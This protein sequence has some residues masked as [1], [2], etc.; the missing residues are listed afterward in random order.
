MAYPDDLPTCV[1]GSLGRAKVDT[2]A[3]TDKDA[4][5]DADEYNEIKS[6][7]EGLAA[8]LQL[9]NARDVPAVVASAIA[10]GMELN[11]LTPTGHGE[12]ILPTHGFVRVT[13]DYYTAL[14]PQTAASIRYIYSDTGFHLVPS[15]YGGAGIVTING[16]A[17]IAVIASGLSVLIGDGANAWVCGSAAN[18]TAISAEIAA[19]AGDVQDDLDAHTTNVSNAHSVTAVQAGALPLGGNT[20]NSVVITNGSGTINY[21]Q[22][23]TADRLLTWVGSVLAFTQLTIGMIADRLIT[24]AKM[25]AG[26]AHTLIGRSANSSGDVADISI[27]TDEGVFNVSGVLTSQK[28]QTANIADNAITLAKLAAALQIG[29]DSTQ[30]QECSG[31]SATISAGTR[32][33]FVDTSGGAYSLTCPA[34]S[35]GQSVLIVKVTTD[36]N[37]ITLIRTGSETIQ[38]VA[39]NYVLPGS[40]L[41][42]YFS[43]LLVDRSSTARMVA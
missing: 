30:V 42:D 40:T 41:G 26:A 6:S 33:A 28:A 10:K 24:W 36:A 4:S 19:A 25:P 16:V 32:I 21:A 35:K 17:D 11:P 29:V 5:A 43:W 12:I 22:A 2:S 34:I 14:S 23:S 38:A 18:Y 39:A 31:T 27:G 3:Y 20:T 37:A 1:D 13:A 15:D 9:P 8:I 7:V